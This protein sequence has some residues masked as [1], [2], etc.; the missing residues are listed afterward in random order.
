MMNNYQVVLAGGLDFTKPE[1]FVA[2]YGI[3]LKQFIKYIYYDTSDKEWKEPAKK[4]Q[5]KLS[6][7]LLPESAFGQHPRC[8]LY[9]T[10]YHTGRIYRGRQ[11]CMDRERN[12]ADKIK[13][14]IDL[15]SPLIP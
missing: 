13:T 8:L 3:D 11:W 14:N 6:F 7:Q 15:E 2:E 5:E 9:R 4:A 1:P 10:G 12:R